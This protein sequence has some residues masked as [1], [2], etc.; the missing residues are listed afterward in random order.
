MAMRLPVEEALDIYDIHLWGAGYF[1]ISAEG[2][3]TV[4]PVRNPRLEVSLPRVVAD[5]RRQGHETPILFRFP[6]IL[7]T[8]V[9]EMVRAFRAAMDEF[10][11]HGGD[12]SPTFPMKVN[13]NRH[14][15]EALLAAGRP[16]RLGLEAGSKP[17][18]MAA[19][20]MDVAPGALTTINGY[21]DPETLALAI[22]GARMGRRVVIVVEK[23]FEVELILRAFEK[24]GDGPLPEVGLRVRMFARGAGKW[25]ESSGLTAKFGLTTAALLAAVGQFRAAQQLD[26]LS[27]VHFHIGSQIPDIRRLKAAFREGARIY[28]KLRKMGVPLSILNMGGGLAV[29]YDGS[30]TASD[31][32]R[33][34]SIAEYANDA[35][36]I[37]KEVCLEE[38]VPYPLI[39]TESGRA[40]T[41]YH[42]LLVT[43]VL[44][45]ITPDLPSQNGG[46]GGTRE[47]ARVVQ[48]LRSML[49]DMSGKN[50]REYFHDATEQ[51]D[52][53]ATLFNH[54]LITMEDR[55][56]AEQL[57]WDI[58]RRALSF[59]RREKI[60][61]EEFQELEQALDQKYIVN[62]SVFQSVPDHWALE[63]L[64]PIVPISR[65][66]E[67]PEHKATLC[68]ITCD[69]DGQIDHFVDIKDV[70][71]VLPLHDPIPGEPY[72]L[73]ICLLGA[74]QDVMGDLHNLYGAPDEVH[75]SIDEEGRTRIDRIVPGDTIADVL[76]VFRYEQQKLVE[77]V[78]RQLT[79]QVE[80]GNLAAERPEAL[81]AA[82]RDLFAKGT[83]LKQSD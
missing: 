3:L 33:N 20:A 17:E 66:R 11:F 45:R 56:L 14:V 50:Y 31:A 68:D 72:D 5:L 10:G 25:R 42:S 2:E 40:L 6:Q 46:K 54:G 19:L 13:Q 83:Y 27:M 22:M 30:K 41:A 78:G 51:R 60:P 4:R 37:V 63:Q 32:S 81:L 16:S 70:K 38:R 35:V 29:D 7:H 55:G 44:A 23:P 82:Y 77:G 62:F 79:A 73:A 43:N 76:G 26:R 75:V 47:H 53:M 36:Y 61:L 67:P 80:A 57:F 8:S 64:F 9:D 71:E 69:S 39:T 74:Y 48:E 12:Y 34:Y 1:G 15:V 65:L 24:A 59:A 49:E 28:A 21:K 58:A 18:L 52:E